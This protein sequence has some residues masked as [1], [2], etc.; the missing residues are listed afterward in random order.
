MKKLLICLTALVV[1][2][3]CNSERGY[4]DYRGLPM[5][6]SAK[7]MCDSFMERG[8]AIDS[9]LCDS[10]STFVLKSAKENFRLD[11]HY[12][13]DTITLAV[14]DG[15]T[16]V[17]TFTDATWGTATITGI[18]ATDE[19]ADGLYE[20][21]GGEGSFVMNNIRTGQ[22]ETFSCKLENATVNPKD[23]QLT[24]V[25]S[26]YMEVGHGNMTFAFQTGEMPT[27]E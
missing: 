19:N 4:L 20:L 26:A 22:T 16:L 2:C 10:G 14:G 12:A 24:A 18:Q 1:L 3:A 8:F 17:A 21:Q 27:E 13:N 6:M 25:I 23:Q 15:G 11:I 7:A 9:A 5:N